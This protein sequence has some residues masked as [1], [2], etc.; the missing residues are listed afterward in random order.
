VTFGAMGDLRARSCG[1]RE[2]D[3][4]PIDESI[5]MV[6]SQTSVLL[7]CVP[8]LNMMFIALYTYD[9]L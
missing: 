1:V 6:E 8:S 3:G 9:T 5:R 2:L 7:L 4:C